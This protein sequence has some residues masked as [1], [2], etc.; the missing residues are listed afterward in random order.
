MA[1]SSSIMD[2]RTMLKTAVVGVGTTVVAGCTGGNGGDGQ[3]TV[4]T[5]HWGL[6]D[7]SIALM[8]GQ[9]ENLFEDAGLEIDRVD[10]SGG[11][12]NVRT[13]AAGDAD[14]GLATGMLSLFG[15]HRAGTNIQ[16]VG[17]QI[18]HSDAIWYTTEDSE[19]NDVED[20][21]GAD[22]A[23]SEEGSSTHIVVEEA[24]NYASLSDVNG[25]SAGG[26]PD[27]NAELE[28]GSI[29]VAWTVPPFFIDTIESGDNKIVFAGN[30]IPPPLMT[31]L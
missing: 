21:D 19:Y 30:S 4:G 17:N 14:V 22:V 29:D 25:V 26:P 16:V 11:G 18:G 31:S 15:S 5:P 23:Y 9:E 13:V 3:V 28:G 20:L 7:P 12:E 8:V 10:M 2:R 1:K 24:I 27:T 6:W